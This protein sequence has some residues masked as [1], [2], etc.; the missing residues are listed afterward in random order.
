M[1][2]DEYIQRSGAVNSWSSHRPMSLI[3]QSVY[4]VAVGGLA[5]IDLRCHNSAYGIEGKCTKVAI[6][7]SPCHAASNLLEDCHCHNNDCPVIVT[8]GIAILAWSE[9]CLLLF[10]YEILV[11]STLASRRIGEQKFSCLQFASSAH[12]VAS[13]VMETFCISV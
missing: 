2:K 5:L 12:N 1:N 11:D 3:T 9:A 4:T 8:A 10:F 7:Q 6:S 13:E